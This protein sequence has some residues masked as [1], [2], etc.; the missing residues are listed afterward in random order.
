M[1]KRTFSHIINVLPI[2]T[3]F[4]TMDNKKILQTAGQKL[5]EEIFLQSHTK[6]IEGVQS[7]LLDVLILDDEQKTREE[8]GNPVK[9][10]LQERIKKANTMK[11]PPKTQYL[12]NM[13]RI[14]ADLD[15]RIQGEKLKKNRKQ[16]LNLDKKDMFF[17]KAVLEKFVEEAVNQAKTD[18]A[19]DK[20]IIYKKLTK[21]LDHIDMITWSLK[22][23]LVDIT[24][25]TQKKN[26]EDLIQKLE[27]IKTQKKEEK[28]DEL[29]KKLEGKKQEKKEEDENIRN[30]ENMDKKYFIALTNK[31]KTMK[32]GETIDLSMKG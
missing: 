21:H 8:F 16:V 25:T 31:L 9:E 29:K 2:Y 22:H 10:E 7:N 23:K 17:N 11:D 13:E 12:Q 19:I 18:N 26:I 30:I 27:N 14:I 1:Q 5:E 28:E 3:F 32:I 6:A 24:D 20:E 4:T 15:K